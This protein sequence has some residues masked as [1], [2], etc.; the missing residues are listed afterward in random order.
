MILLVLIPTLGGRKPKKLPVVKKQTC[1]T[2]TIVLVQ[3][4]DARQ[5]TYVPYTVAVY[6]ALLPTK[7]KDMKLECLCY[8]TPGS[9]HF[10]CS[11]F[12]LL[13]RNLILSPSATNI[14]TLKN[15]RVWA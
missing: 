3:S 15:G 10:S 11:V 13:A 7:K 4:T 9:V 5:D 1:T 2:R 14:D 6:T 12:R 8:S